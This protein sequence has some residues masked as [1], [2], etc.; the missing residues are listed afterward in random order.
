MLPVVQW[1]C[2]TCTGQ[3][4]NRAVCNRP[5]LEHYQVGS[6]S[7]IK[8]LR[9][10]NEVGD[11]VIISNP[12]VKILTLPALSNVAGGSLL[13]CSFDEFVFLPL[14]AASASCLNFLST[15]KKFHHGLTTT[16]IHLP[17]L[18][19]LSYLNVE[20]TGKLDCIALGKNLSS[21]TF[22]PGK[23]DLYK[24][25]TC[26][27]LYETTMYNFLAPAS[28]P[29][30]TAGSSTASSTDTASASTSTK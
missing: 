26:W 27:T 20:S 4:E 30:S 10:R 14:T 28:T 16:R 5:L 1:R 6:G 19:T 25:F 22:T 7:S 21:L 13:W 18:K 15:A 11:L 17:S 24:G 2:T 9:G 23:Y 8:G 29:T 3:I 12:K